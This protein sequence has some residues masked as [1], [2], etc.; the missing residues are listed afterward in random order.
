MLNDWNLNK[1]IIT[2]VTKPIQI[3]YHN[4]SAYSR[5]LLKKNEFFS[6][7]IAFQVNFSSNQ[8]EN[9][10]IADSKKKQSKCQ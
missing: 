7:S 5:T 1:K 9:V 2:F 3:Q 8:W 10:A 4:R 6:Q